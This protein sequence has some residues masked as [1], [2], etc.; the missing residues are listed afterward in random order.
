MSL[1]FIL[2]CL[3]IAAAAAIRLAPAV[4]R[5]VLR[6]AVL[7]FAIVPV[8]LAAATVGWLP[9]ALALCGVVALFPNPM[10]ALANHLIALGRAKVAAFRATRA[11]THQ[12]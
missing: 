3:W 8:I 11:G 6:F 5:P 1:A 7:A 10:A 4:H 9:A 12:A 2:Y